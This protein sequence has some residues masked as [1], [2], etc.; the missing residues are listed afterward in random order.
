MDNTTAHQANHF[1]R[2]L[3]LSLHW[4]NDANDFKICRSWLSEFV[5]NYGDKQHFKLETFEKLSGRES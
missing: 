5:F 1:K 4:L 2:I 3:S